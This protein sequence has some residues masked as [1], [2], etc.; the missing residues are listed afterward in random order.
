MW[1]VERKSGALV[2]TC[3]NSMKDSRPS[4]STSDSSTTF[5]HTCATSSGESS[6]QVKSRNV[7][8]KSD[9][10][11]CWSPSKSVRII[12]FFV[13][14]SVGQMLFRNSMIKITHSY[15]IFYNAHFAV[16]KDC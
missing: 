4:P 1:K 11:R 6:L 7:C 5:S 15:V 16:G 13:I 3:S 12:Y 10:P 8:C 14:Y 2:M 9:G